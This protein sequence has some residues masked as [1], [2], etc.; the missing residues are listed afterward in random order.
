MPVS[1]STRTAMRADGMR[2]TCEDD[3]QASRLAGARKAPK[4]ANSKQ[5]DDERA[6]CWFNAGVEAYGKADAYASEAEISSGVLSELRS[7][8][9]SVALRRLLLFLKSPGAALA[10]CEAFLGDVEVAEHPDAVLALV[11][12]LLDAIGMVARPIEAPTEDEVLRLSHDE[13]W[14]A[15]MF[16]EHLY[17]VAKEKRG[18]TRAQVDIALRRGGK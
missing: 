1:T 8:K 15:P 9:R 10:F 16:R 3:S 6:A 7:G 12:P 18:W 14:E 17:R 13:S 5:R 11:A 2:G 4:R